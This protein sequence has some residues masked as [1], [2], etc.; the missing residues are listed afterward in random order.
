V[1][2]VHGANYKGK[3]VKQVLSE[4]QNGEPVF[5]LDVELIGKLSDSRDPTS[6]LDTAVAGAK[7]EV[8]MMFIDEQKIEYAVGDLARLGFEDADISK[9]SPEHKKHF[10]LVG[11]EVF[12]APKISQSEKGENIYWNLRSPRKFEKK[13][14]DKEAAS[15]KGLEYLEKI[16]VAQTSLKE[17]QAARAAARAAK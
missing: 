2:Y 12:V 4:T 16:K 10:S 3:I 11:K 9:L 7:V 5:S 14:L 17:K 1:S 15:L 6:P 13:A 8:V